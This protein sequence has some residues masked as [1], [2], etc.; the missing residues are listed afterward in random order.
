MI[1]IR[2]L[3]K[4][5]DDRHLLLSSTVVRVT[6]HDNDPDIPAFRLPAWG[7]EGAPPQP[8]PVEEAPIEIELHVDPEPVLATSS[9][10]TGSVIGILSAEGSAKH[11]DTDLERASGVA[12]Q[13][14]LERL[15]DAAIASGGVDVYGIR[16]SLIA[17]KK[18]VVAVAYGTAVSRRP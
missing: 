15:R 2:I 4:G 18:R 1:E 12:T 10:P 8:P 14:A 17:R 7:E 5:T 6:D 3:P 13:A 16:I 9:N 11:D